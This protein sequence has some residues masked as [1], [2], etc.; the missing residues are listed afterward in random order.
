[1]ARSPLQDSNQGR[2]IAGEKFGVLALTHSHS[3]ESYQ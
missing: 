2:Q 1:M 3:P